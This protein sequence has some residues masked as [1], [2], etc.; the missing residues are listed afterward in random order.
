MP[1]FRV[2]PFFRLPRGARRARPQVK[3]SL[4]LQTNDGTQPK[5]SV[6]ELRWS[7]MVTSC[8]VLAVY[9]AQALGARA[10]C[11][12]AALKLDRTLRVL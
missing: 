5:E 2:V 9:D 10:S 12:G 8:S 1:F 6:M 11:L 7:L 3:I 4:F